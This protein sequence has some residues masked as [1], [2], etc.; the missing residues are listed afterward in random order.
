MALPGVLVL[1]CLGSSLR[2]GTIGALAGVLAS[3]GIALWSI[4]HPSGYFFAPMDADWL[5]VVRER[6]QFLFPE[7]WSPA[8]WAEN[9]RP[10]L[11]LTIGAMALMTRGC[12]SCARRPCWSAP[13]AWP[14]RSSQVSWVR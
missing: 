1:L 10:F 14:S 5:Q 11:S 9:A 6:S 12:A 13:R 7:L 8:D 4:L 2:I 3:L